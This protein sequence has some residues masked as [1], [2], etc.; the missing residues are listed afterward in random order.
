MS[1]LA[2]VHRVQRTGEDAGA[3]PGT[4]LSSREPAAHPRLL[5]WIHSVTTDRTA[6]AATHSLTAQKNI[7]TIMSAS[8]PA[9]FTQERTTK[10]GSAMTD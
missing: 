10:L 1:T 3:N 9:S 7:H 2:R 6:A 8:L 5:S 4:F